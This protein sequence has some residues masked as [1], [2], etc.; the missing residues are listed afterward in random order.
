MFL[1]G[2]RAFA[3]F[4][5]VGVDYVRPERMFGRTTNSFLRNLGWAKRGIFSFSDA[6]L[7]ALLFVATLLF[8]ATVLLGAV[9]V[10]LRLL[11]PDLSPAGVTTVLLA[12][13]F[14]GS[15]NL[16]AIALVGEYVGRIFTEAK[17]RPRFI[18]RAVLRRGEVL[19]A[20]EH[21]S[22]GASR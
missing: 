18:R 15:F 1:R 11:F 13:L 9:Q 8:G 19:L 16:L 7:N 14:F 20:G 17:G 12:I 6:P 21:G 22:G 10:T 2:M 4:R 3:G 5:Q